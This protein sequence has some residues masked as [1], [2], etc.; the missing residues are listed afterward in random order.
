MRNAIA[1]AVRNSPAMNTLMLGL[2]VVGM[3]SMVL[4]RREVFPQFELEIILVTVRYPGATPEE[5]ERGICQKI[6]EAVH[7]IDGITKQLAVAR[8]GVGFLVL[9]LDARTEPEKVLNEIRSE[10]DAIPSFP[11][12][13]EEP[14]IQQ[15][16]FRIPAIKVGVIG[17]DTDDPDAEMR[18]RETAERVRDELIH[19]PSVSQARILG[20]RD[21]QIDVEISE[22]TLRKYGL[23]LQ[24]VANI[25]RRQNVELPGGSIKTPNEEIL[26]RAK[27]KGLTGKEIERLPLLET[28]SGD[29]LLVRDLADV[30]DAFVDDPVISMINGR[31]GLVI[32]VERT[33][34]EDL[35]ALTR[36]VRDYLKGK[37]LPGYSLAYWADQSVD[38]ADRIDML[39]RNGIQ[40]LMLVFFVLA[41][42]L[43]LRLAF[44]VALGIPISVFGA[45]AVLFFQ[46]QTLNML[47]LF[48]FLMA[49]GIVVDDAIVIGENIYEHRQMGKSFTQAA[50]DGTFEVIPAVT[51]SVTT[52]VIAF[53]PLLF[54]SGVMGKFIAVMPVAVIAML[55]ISL[56]EAAFIL[57]CHLGHR[58][59]LVFLILGI[60]L[61][62]VRFVARWMHGLHVRADRGLVRFINGPYKRL[63]TRA[64]HNTPIVYA[65][66]VGVLLVAGGFVQ[67]G[68]VP[69]VLFP[70]IDSR[71]IAANL[72][73]PDGTP[74][75]VTARTAEALEEAAQRV[76]RRL[77][78]DNPPLVRVRHRLVGKVP[79]VNNP[80]GQAAD[81]AGS[82]LATIELELIPVDT[83][84]VTSEELLKAWRALWQK[85]YAARFPGVES[86]TFG[87]QE[88]GP[89]GR[90]IE[91]K[92]LAPPTRDGVRQL[93]LATEECKRELATYQGVTDIDDDSRP[94]KIEFQIRLRDSARALGVT[95]ADIAETVRAAF[96]GAEAM[97]LQR[98]R[99]EVKLMVRYPRDERRSIAAINEVRVRTAD[100]HEYPLPELARIDITRG[101]SEINRLDQQRSITIYADIVEGEAN[102]ANVIKNLEKT[103]VPELLEKYPLVRVR[104]EGQRQRSNESIGSLIRG[105]AI[106]LIAMFS[107][108]TIQFRSYLQPLIIMLIIPF[109]F[110]GAVF[111]HALMGLHFT[112]F[113]VFGMIALTGVVVNDSIV[114]IDFINRALA[115]NMPLRTALVEAGLRR[116]RPVVLTSTTTVAGLTPMMLERSFQAQVL[117]PMAVS[118]CFGL[119]FSTALILVMVPVIYQF[120]GRWLVQH[121]DQIAQAPL[122]QTED[123]TLGGA[124]PVIEGST[125][126]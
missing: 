101:Y 10:V 7:A 13:A 82:H 29:V 84:T 97:R 107:L 100:G 50:I 122:S 74:L 8:E 75:E 61:W 19:L 125:P 20:A 77:Q 66:A 28:P 22:E 32:A 105:L 102:S 118:L 72:V 85:E 124:R 41:I 60:V 93:E 115:D 111:G 25:L 79:G 55:L 88:L 36:D 33:R 68:I 65:S 90:P 47:S 2:L 15:I 116:F 70:K 123:V 34:A 6:E 51:T 110:V 92:L 112:L 48:A 96:Y 62:P 95:V 30:R 89:G 64:L 45:G 113:S 103:F 14:E 58:D 104:W 91:F 59:S 80:T 31:P 24:Q 46:D 3:A 38:V 119:V 27:N 21:Y 69:W 67:S 78:G 5:V 17:R 108:L 44:W 18:L 9:E 106:A 12:L 71:A 83:R 56:V 81:M 11:E 39:V 99:H 37:Q 43:D 120:Y 42:F 98:G 4:M 94:G 35:L 54:V 109:G 114:L 53:M 40:G 52:T 23:T 121:R 73:Y 26:L 63:L 57:P 117:I 76:A 86:L 16:T 87:S 1:W 126:P 49:L